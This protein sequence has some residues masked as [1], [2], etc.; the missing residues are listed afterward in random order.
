MTLIYLDGGPAHGRMYEIE[1]DIP[2]IWRIPIQPSV[3]EMWREPEERPWDVTLEYEIYR[4]VGHIT[5]LP[6]VYYLYRHDIH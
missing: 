2:P 6:R 5:D 4:R 3:A 1:G